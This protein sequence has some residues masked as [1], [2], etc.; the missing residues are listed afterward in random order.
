MIDQIGWT[1]V[2]RGSRSTV[3]VWISPGRAGVRGFLRGADVLPAAS[4]S[5]P[6]NVG[7]E[8]EFHIT[9]RCQT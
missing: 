6:L 7:Q 2:E 1:A 3:L 5:D 8:N 9:R 4:S